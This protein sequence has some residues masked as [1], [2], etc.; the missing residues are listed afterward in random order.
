MNI[1]KKIYLIFFTVA[2]ALV[3]ESCFEHTIHAR[4]STS[5]RYRNRQG[6]NAGKGLLIGGLGGATIVGIA[7]GRKGALIG[8]GAGAG[9]G[10]FA[11]AASD[12]KRRRYK[13]YDSD[14]CDEYCD[15]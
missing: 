4:N 2:L 12:N 6:S 11:G 14:D 15:E 8:L 5:R 10:A 7:G 9:L 3:G 1:R 13:D